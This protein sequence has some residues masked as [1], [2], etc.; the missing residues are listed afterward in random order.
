MV[1]FS[2]FL[3]KIC[4]LASDII[5]LGN[6]GKKFSFVKVRMIAAKGLNR[7]LTTFYAQVSDEKSRSSLLS[8]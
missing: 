4:H 7:S 1:N 8:R 3:N 6:N 2:Y 5:L